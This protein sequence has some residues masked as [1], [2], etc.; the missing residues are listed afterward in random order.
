M[1]FYII[2][3]L[4]YSVLIVT[5]V[6]ACT[7]VL[8]NIAAGDPAAAALGKNAR[9]EEIESFRR[10]MG[11]DL[12]LFFGNRCRTEAFS[13]PPG[14]NSRQG[15]FQCRRNFDTREKIVAVCRN[16]N[17]RIINEATI[18]PDEQNIVL[19]AGTAKAEFYRLQN[20]PFNSQFI[21]ALSE[22][23]HFKAAFPYIE[24]FDFGPSIS[25]RE[26]VRRIILRG[27]VP[28]LAL[29]LPVFIGEILAGVLL[30]LIA[31]ARRNRTT[32]KIL[33]VLSVAG[34]SISYLVVIIV[35]QWFFGY[36]LGW[37]PLWGYEG[38]KTMI[39]PVL[40]GTLCG[41]GG[42]LRFF[43]TVF[44]NELG[45]EYLRTATAKGL[46]PVKVYGTHLL[47]NSAVQIITKASGGLP[48]LFTGSLLLE[49]FFGIPG[50]GFAGVDALYNSDI[51]L[52][53]A[54]VITSSILFVAIN[55]LAD[56]I[57]AKA[58]PR[59]RLQ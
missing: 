7:F 36:R 24:F 13:M 28:S 3:R 50:L 27:I 30:A 47:R 56:L 45:A 46:S 25:T 49:S 33:V 14:S 34:M 54:V 39:L 55:L 57:C 16:S 11:A 19:P 22:V 31:A 4:A 37:F 48:F 40:A 12:P 53:K 20:N 42:N 18:L 51:Q 9:P 2:R 41:I 29:M 38:V 26:P 1:I 23:V 21:R 8:F 15:E 52:L 5:G 17:G 43:R 10:T 58:D 35:T 6:I 44:V 32:D 59:I